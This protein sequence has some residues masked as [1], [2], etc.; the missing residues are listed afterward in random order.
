[1]ST[2]NV[3]TILIR[4]AE[5]EDF[6]DLQR[7]HGQPRAVWGTLQLPYPSAQVWRKR[8]EKQ[9]GNHYTL[10]AC[11]RQEVVGSLGLAVPDRSPRRWHVGEIG[12]AVHDQWQGRGIGTR[13]LA[14]ALELADR[15]LNLRRL[16]L[17]V[18][19]DNAPAVRLYEKHGFEVEGLLRKHSFRDGALVDAYAMARLR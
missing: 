15:W 14:A 1:M 11:M 10:V 16:E 5:P 8:L 18:Y 3:E 9:A 19:V 2:Q 13:L 4:R 12:M 17:S 6:R 7:I